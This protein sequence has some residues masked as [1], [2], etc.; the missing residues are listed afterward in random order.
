MASETTPLQEDGI[1]Y[2]VMVT[3]PGVTTI[4]SILIRSLTTFF[5][6]RNVREGEEQL[7]EVSPE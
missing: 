3:M 5:V 4:Q 6:R 2:D 7:N 1:W